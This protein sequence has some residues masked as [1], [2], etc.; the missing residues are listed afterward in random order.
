MKASK[1]LL[2]ILYLGLSPIII[3]LLLIMMMEMKIGDK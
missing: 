3:I 1:I 2:W